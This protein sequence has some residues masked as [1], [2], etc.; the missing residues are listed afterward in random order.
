MIKWRT[1][2]NWYIEPRDTS[3]EQL[4]YM[5]IISK[6]GHLGGGW[7]MDELCEKTLELKGAKIEKIGNVLLDLSAYKDTDEYSD[8]DI[9]NEILN[10]V[11][12]TKDFEAVVRADN[13]WPILY[14]LSPVRKNLLHCFD[15]SAN[16][17]VLEVGA[18][19]GGVTGFLCDRFESV[20]AV[21]TSKRRAE[22]LANR[23][24]ER[25][26]LSVIVGNLN[27]IELNEKFDV[28]TLIGVLEYAGMFTESESPYIDFLAEIRNYLKIGGQLVLAIENR[29]GLK[30]WAGFKEDHIGQYFKGI[31]GYDSNR[32]I[33]TFGK[34]E[35]VKMLYAAGFAETKFYYP[36]PDFKLPT[37]IFGDDYKMIESEIDLHIP[38]YDN[39]RI[40]L[41]DERKVFK[42]IAKEG[43]LDFFAN[44]F[45]VFAKN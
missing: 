29:Y 35:L 10:I 27:D 8:D 33:A 18:D 23:H 11:R 21:E 25:D 40:K 28:V 1:N 19:C 3:E 9:E 44:S 30:Y 42:N 36:F 15:F 34:E 22:I 45:L 16:N 37:R 17:S 5:K 4:Y 43:K 32:G 38:N 6:V 26:N 20:T 31:E 12:N 13:R 24:S 14:H 2:L 41:F 7:L 39:A